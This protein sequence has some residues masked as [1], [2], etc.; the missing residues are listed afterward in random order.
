MW[1]RDPTEFSE[2]YSIP[3]SLNRFRCT[4]EHLKP[5]M[6]GG[7]DRCDNLVAACQFCNQTRHRMRK[8]LSPAEYQRHVR[9]R[10]AAG[11]WH[12]PLYHHCRNRSPRRLS[13]G[14]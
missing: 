10:T 14:D 7:D 12:P 13:K 11:R 8:T 6:N 4:V 5:R 9:K 3:G 2:R 1:D